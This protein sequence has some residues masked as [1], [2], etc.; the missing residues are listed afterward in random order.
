MCHPER[1]P[2]AGRRGDQ[3]RDLR[4]CSHCS[5]SALVRVPQVSHLRPGCAL[6]D[7]VTVPSAYKMLL[8]A[9]WQIVEVER[10]TSFY[11]LGS[12][13]E[14]PRL[15]TDRSL[16]RFPPGCP[17]A[18]ATNT[19]LQ[20]QKKRGVRT[21]F[22]PQIPTLF[23]RQANPTEKLVALATT[24][25]IWLPRQLYFPTA[26]ICPKRLRPPPKPSHGIPWP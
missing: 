10:N 13:M 21:V 5:D 9:P 20:G 17:L 7:T 4:F 14:K 8:R 2:C 25:Q 26:E 19:L 3:S 12:T 11:A 18:I 1:S 16:V 15:R 22:A 24:L 6:L 23:F